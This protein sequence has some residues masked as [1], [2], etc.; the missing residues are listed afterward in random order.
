MTVGEYAEVMKIKC[1]TVYKQIAN[2][3]VEVGP[4]VNEARRKHLFPTQLVAEWVETAIQTCR[5]N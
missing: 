2:G 1:D 3:T 4:I 5:Y